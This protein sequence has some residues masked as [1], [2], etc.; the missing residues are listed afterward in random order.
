MAKNPKG[1]KD[2]RYKNKKAERTKDR[3]DKR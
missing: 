2:I 3:K 1:R